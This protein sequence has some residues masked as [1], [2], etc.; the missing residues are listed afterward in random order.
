[1]LDFVAQTDHMYAMLIFQHAH[2]QDRSLLLL[3]SFFVLL[4]CV[5]VTLYY[6]LLLLLNMIAS[7]SAFCCW[8]LSVLKLCTFFIRRK[9]RFGS[10]RFGL[11]F[12]LH[13]IRLHLFVLCTHKCADNRLAMIF[14]PIKTHCLFFLFFWRKEERILEHS[15]LSSYHISITVA[16]IGKFSY[17]ISNICIR[18]LV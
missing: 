15:W 2:I 4:L 3:P 13:R 9:H 5:R 17:T 12:E 11:M 6:L 16:N 7:E 18:S 1:M 8:S 14:I 10:N